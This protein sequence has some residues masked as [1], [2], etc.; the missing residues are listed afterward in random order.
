MIAG[1]YRALCIAEGVKQQQDVSATRNL[2]S[3]KQC[4][5]YRDAILRT[6]QSIGKRPRSPNIIANVAYDSENSN[7]YDQRRLENSDV[8]LANYA[9][10]S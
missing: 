2:H 5:I 4:V 1:T 9:S 3:V 10:N 6:T 8:I 7:H